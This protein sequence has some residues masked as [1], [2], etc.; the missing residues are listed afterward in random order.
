MTS[1]GPP[2]FKVRQPT[3]I[4]GGVREKVR[5][6]DA[7]TRIGSAAWVQRGMMVESLE[8]LRLLILVREIWRRILP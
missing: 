7:C 4:G 8:S 2:W 6:G 3:E 5:C 1:S